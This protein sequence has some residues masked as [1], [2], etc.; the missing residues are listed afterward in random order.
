[1]YHIGNA[2]FADFSKGNIRP[3]TIKSGDVFVLTKN[4][5]GF[6]GPACIGRRDVPIKAGKYKVT[7]KKY[8]RGGT[9]TI[10]PV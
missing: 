10:Q 9:L 2:E 4:V 6:Q 5:L 8:F 1:M 3:S 7:S